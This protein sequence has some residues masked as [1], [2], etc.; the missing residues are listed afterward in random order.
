MPHPLLDCA[1]VDQQTNVFTMGRTALV[2]LSDGTLAADKFRGSQ[3]SLA[4]VARACHPDRAQR[5]DS[6]AAFYRAWQAAWGS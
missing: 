2:F 5:F 1:V 3:T 6:L 4:V